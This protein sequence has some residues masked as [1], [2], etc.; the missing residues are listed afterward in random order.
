MLPAG[1][2]S[3]LLGGLSDHFGQNEE[4]DAVTRKQLSDFLQANAARSPSGDATNKPPL[5][6]TS[7]P[8]WRRE[9][10][11][12]SA[13]VFARKAV[14]TRSNCGACHPQA[15]EGDFSEHK[16]KIPKDAPATR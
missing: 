10:D 7:L 11:E 13:A 15:N 6:I 5:R 1:S 2:W 14:M 4:I 3:A 16:V 9:H 12:L 8:W